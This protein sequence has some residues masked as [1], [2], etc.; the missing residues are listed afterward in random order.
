MDGQGMQFKHTYMSKDKMKKGGDGVF[1]SQFK[2]YIADGE[3]ALQD[4]IMGGV[5]RE[6]VMKDVR[7]NLR[8]Q[9]R[10]ANDR[11]NFAA[12]RMQT[13]HQ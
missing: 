1:S 2:S 6:D 9:M 4:K 8:E 11:S 3:N 13:E 7:R 5:S 12:M 10:E